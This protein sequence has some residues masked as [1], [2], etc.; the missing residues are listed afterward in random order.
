M[1]T[2]H[3]RNINILTAYQHY[4]WRRGFVSAFLANFARRNNRAPTANELRR[5]H[6]TTAPRRGV[7]LLHTIAHG[8]QGGLWRARARAVRQ[9][10]ALCG[11][12]GKGAWRQARGLCREGHCHAAG[13]SP[14]GH[15]AAIPAVAVDSRLLHGHHWR[16]L[17]GGNACRTEGRRGLPATQGA[18]CGA[19]AGH[20]VAPSRAHSPRHTGGPPS[21]RRLSSATWPWRSVPTAACLR[22][23]PRARS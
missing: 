11:R 4:I 8:Q 21:R 18:V 15:A 22:W 3:H 2:H 6:T 7:H 12:G 16:G 17:Q 10:E 14:G 1:H 13:H 9:V 20:A 5:R 19:R 23:R